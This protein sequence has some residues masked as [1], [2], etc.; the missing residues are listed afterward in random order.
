MEFNVKK[1]ASDAGVFFSRAMQFTEE[2]LGQAEKTELDAHFENLL[3]R[4][5]CTKNWTEKILRQTEVL[6][7]PNPSARVE[8]FLYEKLDRKVPSRVTNGELLAQYMTEA[9]NDFGPGT[10]YGKTLIKVGETQRRLGAAE[11]EFIRSAS[12]NFL[13]PLRNFLEGD[14]RTI[15][16]ERRILQ[17]RRLDLDACKA[18]VKKA[19]AAEAKAA[20]EHELRL[21]QTEFD[22][23]AEV[24]R[25]LL[26]G[27]SSTH[28]NHLRCLHEFVESQTNYYAQCYQ[29][30]LDLQKQLGSSKGE[31]FS[32]TFVGNAESASPAAATSPPAVAAATLPAVPTIPVVPTIVGVPNTVAEGVLNPN[33]VKPPASGT[34]RARVLYDYEAADSTELALLADEMITVYSLPGMDPDWLIGERGNQK[35]KVPVTYLELL[36]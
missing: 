4:A 10:P 26:E 3:A 11:R 32:G 36:S 19:K 23:Q 1:L 18:R 33:E 30:M 8:E 31:I 27:I 34:R 29:F 15:S 17:N 24:T 21:T 35:G 28:V 2:K 14:W 7:Q 12:I 13:T 20:A 25:L 5:D 16:K 9:A 22:R 6:L